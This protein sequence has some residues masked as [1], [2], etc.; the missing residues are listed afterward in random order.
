MSTRPAT[1]PTAAAVPLA[2][3]TCARLARVAGLAIAGGVLASGALLAAWPQAVQGPQIGTYFGEDP[4]T[5]TD[6]ATAVGP[7]G[8]VYLAGTF[9]GTATVPFGRN[10]PRHPGVAGRCRRVERRRQ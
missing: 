5:T 10:R 6:P 3:G 1:E 7:D 4:V 9:Q 8:S 2:R